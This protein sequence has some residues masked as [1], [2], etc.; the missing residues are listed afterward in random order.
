MNQ[1]NRYMI[2][3]NSGGIEQVIND[4]KNNTGLRLPSL[5]DVFNYVK[6]SHE[7]M[8]NVDDLTIKPYA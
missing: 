3:G 2:Y 4:I 7:E 6:E 8:P 1:E 5:I